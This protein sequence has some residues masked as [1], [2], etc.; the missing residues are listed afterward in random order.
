MRGIQLRDAATLEP[1]GTPLMG[2]SKA[3]R[4]LAFSPD[5]RTLASDSTDG[6]VR[7]WDVMSNEELLTLQW[8]NGIVL[9]Q[10]VSRPMAGR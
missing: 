2:H 1:R 7:L 5:G 10:P 8:P 6:T 4:A 3:I 9:S